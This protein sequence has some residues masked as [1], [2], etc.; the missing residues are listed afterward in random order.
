METYKAVMIPHCNKEE[1]HTQIEK[2]LLQKHISEEG[3]NIER[4]GRTG[5]E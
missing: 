4:T 5:R 3:L 1:T 2:Y